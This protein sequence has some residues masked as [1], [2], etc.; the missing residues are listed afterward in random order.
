VTFAAIGTVI[1]VTM[2]W[3]IRRLEAEVSNVRPETSAAT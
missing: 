3:K 2:T 1:V